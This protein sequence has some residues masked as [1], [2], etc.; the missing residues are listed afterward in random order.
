MKGLLPRRWTTSLMT[1]SLGA[2]HDN[3]DYEHSDVAFISFTG[4]LSGCNPVCC[5]ICS[6]AVFA[7]RMSE[8]HDPLCTVGFG[9]QY[10]FFQPVARAISRCHRGVTPSG[11]LRGAELH[12]AFAQHHGCSAAVRPQRAIAKSTKI[13]VSA[14]G[15]GVSWE[16]SR[17]AP[18]VLVAISLDPI[19]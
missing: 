1:A 13:G 5:R 6:I 14:V 15:W 18:W 4:L 19:F 2:S 11:L 8:G 16:V 9:C 17:C 7:A 12:A 3:G 10:Q